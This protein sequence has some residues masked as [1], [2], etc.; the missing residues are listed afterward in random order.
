MLKVQSHI[1]KFL[2]AAATLPLI[3]CLSATH[4]SGGGNEVFAKSAFDVNKYPMNKLVCNPFDVEPS[5]SMTRGLKAELFYLDSTQPRY[6]A[7]ADYVNNAHY[8]D[9]NLFFSNLY[10]P[11]RYFTSGFPTETGAMVKSDEG[12]DLIEY[13]GLRFHTTLKLAPEQ[14]EGTYEFAIISDDGSI[15]RYKDEAGEWQTLV[16]NDGIHAPRLGCSPV[17]LNMTHNSA[18]ELQIDYYQ[19]PRYAIAAVPLWRKVTDAT[20]VNRDPACGRGAGSDGNSYWFA[21]D[22]NS[23]P[24]ANYTQL[25]TRGWAPIAGENYF[26]PATAEFNPCAVGVAPVISNFSVTDI[27][28]GFIEVEWDTDVPATSQVRYVDMADGT[29]S[30]TLSD[31]L[32]RTHHRLVL[33]HLPSNHTFLIQGVSISETYGKSLT[34]AATITTN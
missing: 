9:Q 31:N 11:T 15:I 8:S 28:D 7:I 30:L 29:E 34:P 12:T 20:L 23:A 22:N 3:G 6:T 14:E 19:G 25:L 21:R 18:V 16:N 32:L 10:V 17:T 33:R 2:L 4:E 13:F 1:T 26:V 5:P 24:S 27:L